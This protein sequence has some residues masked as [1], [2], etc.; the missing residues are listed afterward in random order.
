[1]E[2]LCKQ[3]NLTDSEIGTLKQFEEITNSEDHEVNIGTLKSLHWNLERAIET[4]LCGEPKDVPMEQDDNDDIQ[5]LGSNNVSNDDSNNFHT[6]RRPLRTYMTRSNTRE[7]ALRRTQGTEYS[8]DNEINSDD[9]FTVDSDELDNSSSL[10]RV[11]LIPTE[12]DSVIEAV[13]NFVTVFRARYVDSTPR[14]MPNF[15]QGSL[16]DAIREA[17]E[18]PS[19]PIE[20]RR[21]LAIYVHNDKSVCANIFA[22]EVLCNSQVSALLKHQYIVWPW[23]ITFP[24]NE[25]KLKDWLSLVQ[26]D[27]LNMSLEF[28]CRFENKLP[29]LAVITREKGSFKAVDLCYGADTLDVVLHKLMS[30]VEAYTDIRLTEVKEHK[31]RVEREQIRLEQAQEYEASLAADKARMEAKMKEIEEQRLEEERKLKAE[32]DEKIH[33]AQLASE[34]PEEPAENEAGAIVIKFR[35]P[36]DEQ[37]VR[38][39][40]KSESLSILLKYLSAQGYHSKEYRFMNSDFPKKDVANWDGSKTF[41]EL[42]WPVR[43]QIFVEEV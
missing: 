37:L 24:E 22:T 33:R 36:N 5:I 43:E 7:Q 17:F 20:E 10:N 38:R 12:V 40:R 13:Q 28:N 19:K 30:G 4:H 6:S 29:V 1:M 41:E 35:L 23:D 14:T 34:L 32:E 25:K 21:P 15:F 26:M 27:E 2:D 42:K 31:G 9:D 11:P 39:F 8:D 16:P 3:Y 18:S